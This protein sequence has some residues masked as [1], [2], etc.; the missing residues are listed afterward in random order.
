[1]ILQMLSLPAHAYWKHKVAVNER[2]AAE[3]IMRLQSG[4]DPEKVERPT[5]RFIN[6]YQAM[7]EQDRLNNAMDEAEALAREG[8]PELIQDLE[9]KYQNLEKDPDVQE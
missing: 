3:Y 2:N 6:H 1:M 9:L 8:K 7:Q 5:M 4:G